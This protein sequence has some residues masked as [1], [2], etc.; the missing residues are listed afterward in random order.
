[1]WAVAL[2][3]SLVTACA[4]SYKATPMPF[5]AP[6]SYAN[7]AKVDGGM[8]A[9]RSFA[10]PKEAEEAF[11]FDVRGA[12]FLPIQVVF[13]N[14]GPHLFRINPQQ[15][16]L[17]DGAGNLW[18]ILSDQA[19]YERATRYAQT[20][21]IFKEGAYSG[22]LGAAAGAVIGT[23]IG[24]VTGEGVGSSL[25]KG[26]AV[27]AAAGATLG[28]LKGYGSDT[29]RRESPCPRRRNQDRARIRG[30]GTARETR[31]TTGSRRPSSVHRAPCR[32]HT[33]GARTPDPV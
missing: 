16:F 3:L 4:T 26:A 28:G 10:D 32:A 17:E 8:V 19:A 25:G 2:I 22:F 27:G 1:M 21:E 9:A 5:R 11:G 15:T 24:I 29:A 31:R 14:N 33:P 13:E 20:Q 6:S 23:A 30:T 7:A 12:G 18:P